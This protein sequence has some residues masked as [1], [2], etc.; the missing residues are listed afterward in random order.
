MKIAIIGGNSLI[1]SKLLEKLREDGHEAVMASPDSG[2]STLTGEG[3]AEA[4]RSAAVV[5]DLSKSL[6]FEDAEALKF[7]ETFRTRNLLAA[8]AAAGVRHHVALSVVGIESLSESGHFRAKI[9]QERLVKESSIP[10]SIVHA[11]QCFEFVKSIADAATDGNTVRLAPVLIQPMAADDVASAVS[12][13]A[14]GTP[15]NGTVEV[16]GPE[17]FRF[18]EL[19]R[20]ALT[21]RNDPREVV[22]DPQARYFGATLSE[23]ALVPGD[24]ARRSETRFEDWLRQS[25]LEI[26]NPPP[27]PAVMAD[28][29]IA[30]GHQG[31]GLE[32]VSLD[33]R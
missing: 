9:A 21:A 8:E 33:P 10:Y 3:L 1:A 2:V 5:V 26:Q 30:T 22:S 25:A 11:T 12:R 7:F 15:L 27:P 17:R 13:T 16:A 18:D 14:V 32:H 6:S 20:R 23:R 29:L 24:D 19:V 28:P 4:L 31:R